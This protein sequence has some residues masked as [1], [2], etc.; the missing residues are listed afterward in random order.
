ME[1]H[2]QSLFLLCVFMGDTDLYLYPT[3]TQ[4]DPCWVNFWDRCEVW[5]KVLFL[6]SCMS[7]FSSTISWKVIL[8]PLNCFCTFF[9][10]KIKKVAP[11]VWAYVCGFGWFCWS[12]GLSYNNTTQSWWLA[13]QEVLKLDTMIPPTLLFFSRLFTFSNLIQI[14]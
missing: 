3:R 14:L 13:V 11:L 5:V 2:S 7:S 12:I 9:Y 10:K 4:S 8:S 6:F 1:S